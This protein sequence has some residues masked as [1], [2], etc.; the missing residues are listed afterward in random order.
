MIVSAKIMSSHYSFGSGRRIGTLGSLYP[1][2]CFHLSVAL[3]RDIPKILLH[4]S[5]GFDSHVAVMNYLFQLLK[6]RFFC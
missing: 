6:F 1:R 5:L 2:L 4:P 3:P